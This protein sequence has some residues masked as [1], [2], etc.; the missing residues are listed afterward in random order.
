VRERRERESER[1]SEGERERKREVGRLG[2]REG[3][4]VISSFSSVPPVYILH[5][6][7]GYQQ[8][9]GWTY[10]DSAQNRAPTR[11]ENFASS[12]CGPKAVP[13]IEITSPPCR[14]N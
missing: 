3:E 1:A 10:P 12:P 6:N 13:E 4:T 11:V 7:I 14:E 9:G 8:E 2:G 5:V